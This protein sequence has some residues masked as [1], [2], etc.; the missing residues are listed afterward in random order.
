MERVSN[1]KKNVVWWPAVVNP[2]HSSK[3]GGYDYFE[4]SRKTWE[5]WCEKNDVLFVQFTE[6]VEKDMIDFR[7][8]WQKAIFVFDE[9]ERRGIDYDQIAL[10]DSTAM[11]KWDTPNFFKLTNRKFTAWRDMDNLKWCYD[12]VIGYKEFF[13]NFEFDMTKYINSGF[14]IFNDEHKEFFQSLKRLYLDNK[15][16]FRKLQDEVVKKGND[17]TPINYWLQINNIDMNLDLPFVYNL[18]H[19]HRK[20]ML[21]HNWQ[22]NENQI[23]MFVK[24]GYVW[25]FNGFPKNERTNLMSQVWDYIRGNYE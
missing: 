17:Q 9:L 25:R 13:D 1:M 16:I 6:P 5:Y 15:K 7:I 8:N 18:T 23:P 19:I 11:I 20:E 2:N 24:Y 3:Y 21:R 4:Y 12:S 10:I 22:L 14:M